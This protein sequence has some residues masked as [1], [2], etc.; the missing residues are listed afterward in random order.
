MIMK[1]N[2]QWISVFR[3]YIVKTVFFDEEV[4]RILEFTSVFPGITLQHITN[5]GVNADEDLELHSE[6]LNAL[7]PIATPDA[8]VIAESIFLA[9]QDA[10][11]SGCISESFDV[12]KEYVATVET[13]AG[14]EHPVEYASVM[15]DFCVIKEPYLLL[16]LKRYSQKNKQDIKDLIGPYY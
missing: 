4:V 8:F 9:E 15:T 16:L 1:N 14:E 6:V 5:I 13:T 7:T 3:P 11:I 10:L 12:S 2:L